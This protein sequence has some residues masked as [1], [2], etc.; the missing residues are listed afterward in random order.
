[1]RTT[2]MAASLLVAM[3]VACGESTGDWTYVDSERP[4]IVLDAHEHNVKYGNVKLFVHCFDS[5]D[6]GRRL[7]AFFAFYPSIGSGGSTGPSGGLGL[8]DEIAIGL[9]WGNRD[10]FN[11]PGWKIDRL[12]STVSP[13]DG[14]KVAFLSNL[15][16]HT[17]VRIGVPTSDVDVVLA[18][19]RLKG[20][21][22][23]LQRVMD[24]C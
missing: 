24:V 14:G 3:L 4:S 9:G 15:A 7:D 20:Y 10:G 22:V 2:V 12:G 13:P 1:M 17:E 5:L 18:R 23:A 6:K 11:S 16:D 21:D 19:F 8:Y